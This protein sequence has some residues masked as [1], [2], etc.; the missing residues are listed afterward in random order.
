MLK[1]C[2]GKCIDVECELRVDVHVMICD[3]TQ[4]MEVK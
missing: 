1:S 3:C 4:Q 2:S